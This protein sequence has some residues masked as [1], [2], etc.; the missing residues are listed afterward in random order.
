[1]SSS[2]IVSVILPTYNRA[3][4]LK[5]AAKSVLQQS[6]TSL[7]LII[8]DDA[9]TDATK[10]VVTELNDPRI[11]YI[12]HETNQGGPAARNTG[13]SRA[14]GIYIAFQDSDD[15]WLYDKLQRQVNLLD[16]ADKSTGAVFTGFIRAGKRKAQYVPLPNDDTQR[17]NLLESLLVRNF[18]STQTLLIRKDVLLEIEGFDERLPRFQDWE[19][20][21][22]IAKT[23]D[24]QLI[25]EPMV[26]VYATP[27][28][29]TSNDTVRLKALEII[30]ISH[31]ETFCRYPSAHASFLMNMGNIAAV[32]GLR[33]KAIL[34]YVKGIKTK[35]NSLL[36][37]GLMLFS[38][39]FR[40]LSSFRTLLHK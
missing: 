12:R 37:L 21:I 10:E 20:V 33:K 3:H 25:D 39:L 26:I 31:Y 6:F 38:P 5:R 14:K 13:I 16:S 22:K 29:I 23:C 34:T 30:Y 8:I 9:S 4:L 1:M 11:T 19:L 35:K 27:G 36:F 18:I 15:E 28:N 7:E 32:E 17:G 2:P 24:M 40:M